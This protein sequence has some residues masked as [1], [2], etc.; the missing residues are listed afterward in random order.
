MK[1]R[2]AAAALIA[3]NLTPLARA[4]GGPVAEDIQLGVAEELAGRL[5]G[6]VRDRDMRARQQGPTV[7]T[8]PCW[9]SPPSVP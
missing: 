3:A 4:Q 9:K 8:P 7:G 2:H 1:R 5:Q 6:D